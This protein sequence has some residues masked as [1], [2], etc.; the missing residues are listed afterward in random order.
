MCSLWWTFFWEN[1]VCLCVC[2]N[3]KTPLL[4][5]RAK[6]LP[7]SRRVTGVPGP[8][9]LTRARCGCD[10]R[11]PQRDCT[12]PF[13]S[14]FYQPHL[15]CIFVI[16][17]LKVPKSQQLQLVD[18]LAD[19]EVIMGKRTWRRPSVWKSLTAKMREL[20]TKAHCETKYLLWQ[21]FVSPRLCWSERKGS[22]SSLMMINIKRA[23]LRW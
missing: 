1:C 20:C 8:S 14:L 18:I 5:H 3:E 23:A 22:V 11:K 19:K 6:S 2:V 9:A 7:T 21:D 15:L 17:V 12:P 13:P 16:H 4:F 10:N